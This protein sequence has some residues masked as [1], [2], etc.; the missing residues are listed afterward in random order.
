MLPIAEAISLFTTAG[1]T[2]KVKLLSQLKRDTVSIYYCGGL[3]DYFYGTMTPSTG[4]LQ[5]FEL[6]FYKPGLILRY[7][8]KEKNQG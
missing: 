3:Y 8:E 5:C 6:R 7:P 4:Y 2:E 1:Q